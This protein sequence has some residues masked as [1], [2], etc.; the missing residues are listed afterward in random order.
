MGS[1]DD[2]EGKSTVGGG[3]SGDQSELIDDSSYLTFRCCSVVRS[4]YDVHCH[5]E[6]FSGNANIEILSD[7]VVLVLCGLVMAL[8]KTFRVGWLPEAGGCIL[9]GS[10]LGA[11]LKVMHPELDFSNFSFNSE[12]FMCVLLP[13]IIFQA[14]LSIDKRAF[15]RH[16]FPIGLF[17]VFGTALSAVLAG[18]IV[19]YLTAASSLLPSIPLLDSLVFGSLIASVDP[20]ATL[21]ILSSV[22]VGKT[23][24]IYILVFG[25]SLL[26]DGVAI[27]LFQTLVEHLE[28]NVDDYDNIVAESIKKFFL[29]SFGS[30][31][32]GLI[33]SALSA[34]YF[35]ALM[36]KQKP[37][38]EV[39][40][41]FCFAL[42]PYYVADITGGSGIIAVMTAG[43][44]MDA[45]VIG[46]RTSTVST[47]REEGTC[48]PEESKGHCCLTRRDIYHIFSGNG[49]LSVPATRHIDFVAEV[50]A[51]IMETAI[52]AYVGVFLLVDERLRNLPLILTAI[53]ACMLSR[54]VA[55]YSLSWGVSAARSAHQACQKSPPVED[56]S[57]QAIDK[58]T[59]LILLLSGIRGAVSL[60]LAEDIPMYNAMTGHGSKFKSEL[61][62]MASAS[63]IFTVFVLGALTYYI[64]NWTRRMVPAPE[65][66]GQVR[67]GD[68]SIDRSYESVVSPSEESPLLGDEART[69]TTSHA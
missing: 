17:A 41:F 66:P 62:A 37:V 61:K 60:A 68:C 18:V 28:K 34:I 2:D 53:L 7:L 59:R 32:V 51:S 35:R 13:P 43:F 16:L 26:N 22:G 5:D 4:Y 30:V 49:S 21:S 39:V 63:V 20:V 58:K 33:C 46:N 48:T 27:V 50:L 45:V 6:D 64:L 42:I 3:G 12:M 24:K 23:D 14:A 19:F 44:F 1:D 9:V 65:S 54:L 55:I 29:V 40:M 67:N 8:I 15:R 11:F 38:L 52:F 47:T 36:H 10:A 56:L 25:E 31:A 57:D 69:I